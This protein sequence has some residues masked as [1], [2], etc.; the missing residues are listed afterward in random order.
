MKLLSTL[1]RSTSKTKIFLLGTFWTITFGVCN[2][3]RNDLANTRINKIREIIVSQEDGLQMFDI[4]MKYLEIATYAKLLWSNV[5]KSPL[6]WY[7][8]MKLSKLVKTPSNVGFLWTLV[9][10]IPFLR[11]NL[12]SKNKSEPIFSCSKVKFI[13]R[14]LED[15]YLRNKWADS[16]DSKNTKISLTTFY[17]NLV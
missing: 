2:L 12:T 11:H 9:T 13:F 1:K 6:F 10:N 17:K 7:V 3:L 5:C 14:C 8:G 4:K 15:I 16:G